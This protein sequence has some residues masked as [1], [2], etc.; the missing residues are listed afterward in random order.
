MAFGGHFLAQSANGLI[1]CVYFIHFIDRPCPFLP[2][3]SHYW[4][5]VAIDTKG[6][7]SVLKPLF[8]M[9]GFGWW[10]CLAY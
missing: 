5:A 7:A 3:P 6:N 10:W 1:Q 2:M 4:I 9:V 8:V